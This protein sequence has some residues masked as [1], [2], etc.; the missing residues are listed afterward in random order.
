M[1]S[2]K[3]PTEVQGLD[4]VLGGGIPKGHVVLITGLPGTMKSSLVYSILRNSA[5]SKGLKCL[6]ISLEQTK[7]SLSQQMDSM[8]LNGE[9]PTG[10]L[11]IM[12]V[13][14]MQKGRSRNESGLWM[15]FIKKMIRTRVGLEGVDIIAIDSLEALEVL[16]G[17]KNRRTE[18][19]NFFE[20]LRDLEATSFVLTE[21][22]P[23]QLLFGLDQSSSKNDAN[24]LADGII[25]L[26]MHQVNDLNVQ[27]RLRVVKM[28]GA[29]H[30]TGFY[31]L[32]FEDGEFNVTRAMSV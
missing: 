10:S 15:D 4:E 9:S 25:H 22:P 6:Y 8:G 26:K 27:R 24:F 12:D 5:E 11:P 23:E 7:K 18:L 19:F 30:K 31:A 14:S 1:E 16:A 13:G 21:D 29:N 17:F 32:V 20:N 28:R 3:I 2:V